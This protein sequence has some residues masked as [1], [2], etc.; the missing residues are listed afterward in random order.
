MFLICWHYLCSSVSKRVVL[1][2]IN[3]PRHC[4]WIPCFWLYYLTC[5]LFDIINNIIETTHHPSRKKMRICYTFFIIPGSK[6]LCCLYKL[7]IRNLLLTEFKDL[8]EQSLEGI[9]WEAYY[10][11]YK[12]LCCTLI[13]SLLLSVTL[14]F[15]FQELMGLLTEG[16]F[17]QDEQ[18]YRRPAHHTVTLLLS[19]KQGRKKK[20]IP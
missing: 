3:F 4:F 6:C 16:G 8:Q 14:T 1:S 12:W 11:L 15:L 2:I 13:F 20:Y 19:R 5:I 10:S 7:G 17:P 9:L 18:G